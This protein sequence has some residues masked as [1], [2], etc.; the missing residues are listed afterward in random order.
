MDLSTSKDQ[1]IYRGLST[2]SQPY[3]ETLQYIASMV[4]FLQIG[5]AFVGHFVEH[6]LISTFSV[7]VL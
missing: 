5:L 7:V 6:V 1:L 3:N 2:R 4:Y